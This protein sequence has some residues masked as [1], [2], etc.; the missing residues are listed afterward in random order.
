M[1]TAP[2][3]AVHENAHGVRQTL[4]PCREVRPRQHGYPMQAIS[5]QAMRLRGFGPALFACILRESDADAHTAQFAVEG[6][7]DL[8]RDG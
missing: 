3:R 4:R 1:L 2:L 6:H 5:R 8:A 7:Q